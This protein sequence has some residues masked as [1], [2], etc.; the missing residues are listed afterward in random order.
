LE[1]LDYPVDNHFLQT[2]AEDEELTVEQARIQAAQM[3]A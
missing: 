1:R 3:Q 2:E